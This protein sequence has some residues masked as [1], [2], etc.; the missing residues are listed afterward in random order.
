MDL[1]G[2]RAFVA[3]AEELHYGRAAVRLAVAQPALSQQIIRLE[4]SLGTKLFERS[5]NRVALTDAGRVLLADARRMLELADEAV[6]HV[7]FAER[8]F[9]GDLHVG[10][11]GAM[12]VLLMAVMPLLERER[13][14]VRV[15]ISELTFD[16]MLS[17]LYDERVD[18]GV[19]R[20]WSEAPSMSVEE[21]DRSRLAVALH[22]SHPLAAELSVP[23]AA[24]RYDSFIYFSRTIV[25]G[26][27]ER[28]NA[29]FAAVGVVPRVA[30]E[31]FSAEAAMSFVGANRGII[32]V[33]QGG[34]TERTGH[35]DV[36]FRPLGEPELFVPTVAAWKASGDSHLKQR[37]LAILRTGAVQEGK[38]EPV[39]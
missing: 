35:R 6:T 29:A 11:V 1:R 5:R 20:Q 31:V 8:G 19:F 36:V 26:Y 25:P 15:R 23:L 18:V 10:F 39:L 30:Q 12:H 14:G 28:L 37:V 32:I 9:T 17:G 16:Q 13:P 2:L 38:R 34:P 3:V 27:S 4:E 7:R 24:L 33:P 21:I 22:T